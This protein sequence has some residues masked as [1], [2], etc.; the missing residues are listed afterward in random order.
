MRVALCVTQ[1]SLL[2]TAVVAVGI[3]EPKTHLGPVFLEV[4]KLFGVEGST[5]L[6]MEKRERELEHHL[7]HTNIYGLRW[8][9][10]C[11]RCLYLQPYELHCILILHPTLDEGQGH[12]HRSSGRRGEP[13]THTGRGESNSRN[14][15][16]RLAVGEDK[17]M[18]QRSE[19][20]RG[21]AE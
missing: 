17:R 7:L 14:S 13:D 16:G 10:F 11:A 9:L 21:A 8:R 3:L 12:Q 4:K 18:R 20:S 19:S 5:S 1:K 2:H 6:P 15:Q